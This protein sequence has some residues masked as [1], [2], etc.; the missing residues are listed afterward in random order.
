MARTFAEPSY[1]GFSVTAESPYGTAE[2]AASWIARFQDKATMP[3]PGGLVDA[4]EDE[5]TG[6]T[7]RKK[8]DIVQWAVQLTHEQRLLPY[9]AGLF[10]SLVGGSTTATQQ[11]AT[12][13]YLHVIEDDSDAV[14]LLSV[15]M[16]EDTPAYGQQEFT[17][18][19]CTEVSIEFGRGEFCKLTAQLI[20][21]GAVAAGDD[22]SAVAVANTSEVYLKWSDVDVLVGGTYSE[23]AGVGSVAGGTSI[24]SQI[25]SGKI[26]IKNNGAL[27]YAL[28]ESDDYA[29]GAIKGNMKD[30]EIVKI[31]LEFEPAL[32]DPDLE[33]DYLTG[34]TENV[35][36]IEFQGASM[37]G[38]EAA[39]Y[40]TVDFYFPVT[41][42]NAGALDK[43]NL[44]QT[45][46]QTWIAIKDDSV[47]DYPLWQAQVTNKVTAYLG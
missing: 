19:A 33:L 21:D 17:G 46:T 43:D 1:R 41:R 34:E 9:V 20:G 7:Y 45:A 2:A 39:Y 23:A 40:Y 10:L 35:L 5:Y 28:G 32:A 29:S 31:E 4:D 47:N 38:A 15:T 13:A 26:T 22:L 14:D 12:A 27:L 18:I 42:V 11:A 16:W 37:G 6:S 8:H 24:K 25:R 30:A 36:Q 44:V 3:Q